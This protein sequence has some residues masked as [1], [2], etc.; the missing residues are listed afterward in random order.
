MKKLYKQGCPRTRVP[1]SDGPG[2]PH[3]LCPPGQAE[4]SQISGYHVR[5]PVRPGSGRGSLAQGQWGGLRER[6]EG[7]EDPWPREAQ[8]VIGG[9]PRRGGT[10][11]TKLERHILTEVNSEK[12]EERVLTLSW[13]G[14]GWGG[15]WLADVSEPHSGEPVL[16]PPAH[17]S[18]SRELSPQRLSATPSPL[19]LCPQPP[20]FFPCSHSPQGS[21][22]HHAKGSPCYSFN[23][24]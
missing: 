8:R 14:V 16:S 12:L 10:I 19:L 21:Q 11:A 5:S 9:I 22:G 7:G 20:A 2:Q 17:Q 13:G 1:G 24:K 23:S 6:R 4:P 3:S 18:F 15:G